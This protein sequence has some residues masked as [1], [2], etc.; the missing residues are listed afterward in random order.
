MPQV[1]KKR[2]FW[3]KLA[4]HYHLECLTYQ[5]RKIDGD[6]RERTNFQC[7]ETKTFNLTN[8]GSLKDNNVTKFTIKG[9]AR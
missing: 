9:R 6:F 1:I 7:M 4:S 8:Y 3:A 2:L 5:V